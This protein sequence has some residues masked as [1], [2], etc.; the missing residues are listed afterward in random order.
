MARVGEHD[1][2]WIVQERQDGRNVGNW[3]WTER[4]ALPMAL[5]IF[6]EEF[7]NTTIPCDG[8]ELL[9]ETLDSLTGDLNLMNR[10]G[11]TIF[12]YD[13]ILKLKWS[14]SFEKNGKPV[15][16]KGTIEVIDI[17]MDRD[18]IVRVKLNSEKALNRQLKEYMRKNATSI[19]NEKISVLLDNIEERMRAQFET[20]STERLPEQSPIIPEPVE[21][22]ESPTQ[23]P[24]TNRSK[25]SKS[26]QQK[27][28][29]RA[30]VEHLFETLSSPERLSAFAG[31]NA[32][33]EPVE[34]GEFSLFDG[35]VCGTVQS[36][37][38]NQKIV[39]KWR[40]KEWPENVFSR[41][42]I[43]FTGEGATT[44][45]VLKQTGIPMYDLERTKNG[46]ET[47]FWRRIRGVFGW[48]YTNLR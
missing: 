32:V 6:K 34:N 10:K 18:F 13:L 29:F 30:P 35:N 8:A 4:D 23:S 2:R 3:H 1:E 47:F 40:F 33:F 45:V 48:T 14:G 12:I 15:K 31:S 28:K 20:N 39:Q 37:Q 21:V 27:V 46:W 43:T 41:V 16:A 24:T 22:I 36:I 11:K 42:S 44:T 9:I 26:F 25:N 7:E 5:P 17:D 19:I 38:K